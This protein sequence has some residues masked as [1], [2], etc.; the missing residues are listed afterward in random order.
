MAVYTNIQIKLF[1]VFKLC[2]CRR[3]GLH[4]DIFI[5]FT[6][7]RSRVLCGLLFNPIFYPMTNEIDFCTSMHRSPPFCTSF[8]SCDN[9]EV[10]FIWYHTG[11]IAVSCRLK[12]IFIIFYYIQSLIGYIDIVSSTNVHYDSKNFS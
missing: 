10:R 4:C 7:E 2:F 1:L 5:Y 11:L 12:T 3:N 9:K 6:G 8:C